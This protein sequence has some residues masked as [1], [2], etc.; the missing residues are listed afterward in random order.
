[1]TE[2]QQNP[3]RETAPTGTTQRVLLALMFLADAEGSVSV[4]NAAERLGL[5]PSTV[6]RVLN[7]LVQYGFA[8]YEARSSTYSIG[9]QFYRMAARV[10]SK[11]SPVSIAEHAIANLSRQYDETILLGLYL[12]TERALS[13]VA[14]SDGQKKLL[15]RIEMNT[16]LSLV[17]G[18]SGKAA[19][20]YLPADEI[21][22]ILTRE[23]PSPAT[24][25][26]PPNLEDLLKELA[27]VREQGFCISN[28]EKL[29]GALGIAAPVFGPQA[30][31]GT[32]CLT[33][34][35]DSALSAD[36]VARGREIAAAAKAVS[37]QL[38]G[39]SE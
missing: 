35:R 10:T 26:Q 25:A 37:F 15:Y 5:A 27:R 1:M 21:A 3:D 24:G 7:L 19:L 34:P 12:P 16:P 36:L 9:P 29:P 6:H 17:W 28:N 14:R 30:I 23:K 13:F 33:M 11:V 18:A 39:I 32:I 38:G 20:A 22:A 31:M 8:I 2:S 4:R